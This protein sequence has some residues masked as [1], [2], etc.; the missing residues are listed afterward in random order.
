MGFA[1]MMYEPCYVMIGSANLKLNKGIDIQ[2]NREE[3]GLISLLLFFKNK[4][5]RLKTNLK[6]VR[7]LTRF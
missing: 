3:V 5:C 1:A 4:E 6:C 7:L 2:I